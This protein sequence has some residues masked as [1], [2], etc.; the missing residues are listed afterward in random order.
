MDVKLNLAE[1][2]LPVDIDASEAKEYLEHFLA[3]SAAYKAGIWVYDIKSRRTTFLNDYFKVLELSKIGVVFGSLEEAGKFTPE[4]D[5]KALSVAFGS[6]SPAASVRF[7][8]IGRNGETR[9][10]K[11]HVYRSF[12]PDGSPSKLMCHTVIDR[13]DESHEQQYRKMINAMPDF[14]MVLDADLNILD[15]IMA[16]ATQLFHTR[17]ELVGSNIRAIFV[18]EVFEMFESYVRECFRTGQ[19]KEIE[20]RQD[21]L[22][23]RYYWQ[24]RLVP[25]GGGRLYAKFRD[26]S[27]RIRSIEELL[28]AR[29]K[30][31]QADRM[32]STFLA[33][34][35][36]EIRTPLN[37]IVGFTE[38]IATETDPRV[39]EEYMRI[40][41]ANSELLMQLFNDILD[42]SRIESGKSG[43]NFAETDVTSLV[44][45]AA[46][47]NS[48]KIHPGVGLRVECPDREIKAQTDRKRLMQVLL[49]LITNA[50]KNTTEGHITI[51]LEEQDDI[52]R[53]AVA[54]T[55]C[56]IPKNKLG[57][58]F[59]RFEKLDDAAI[60]SGLG[61]SI[62]QSIV[63]R[64]G[65]RIGVESE[66]GAGST[67]WFTIPYRHQPE[68]PL[69]PCKP[70]GEIDSRKKILVTDESDEGF[71]RAAELLGTQYE[72]VR[73]RNGNEAVGMFI[74]ENPDLV[75]MNI[76]MQGMNGIEATRR[77][78]AMSSSVPIVAVTAN[79]F[80]VEQRWALESGCND[81]ISKPYLPQRLREAIGAFL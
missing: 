14:I 31:E 43:M 29:Q 76:R 3:M 48:M 63:E 66:E 32:K 50:V 34:M 41:R 81:V 70:S 18:P 80:F 25:V 60:G 30:A 72:L 78:R 4:E 7:R 23:K 33:N 71:A 57:R 52:L 62:S 69:P 74:F 28:E 73:A 24:A 51:K 10:M 53:F 19:Y 11:S 67:F 13:I 39:R 64:L 75:M 2:V 9:W 56:G 26:I 40:V 44:D 79:E 37:A 55:G 27:E 49:N 5:R 8:F 58:I 22:G 16:E 17:E 12:D 36:H 47:T 45:E 6:A 54:D 38:V 1:G 21:M 35:S 20:Y 61:L 65:G 59:D 77:I 42:L 68:E 15:L 46:K